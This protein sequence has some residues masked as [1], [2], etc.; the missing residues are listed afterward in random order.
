MLAPIEHRAEFSPK[1]SLQRTKQLPD[2]GDFRNNAA[3]AAIIY[4]HQN[5]VIEV[6]E[7]YTG[8][9]KAVIEE[10]GFCFL[11]SPTKRS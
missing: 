4:Q 10:R 5:G 6:S 2:N 3:N 9:V 7:I 11:R 1:S 8:V